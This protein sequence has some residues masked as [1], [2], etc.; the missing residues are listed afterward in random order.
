MRLDNQTPLEAMAFRQFAA[1]GSL[2]CVV[3]VRGTFLHE[4]DAPLA[5]AQEQVPF[6]FEDVYAG[7]PHTSPMLMQGDLVP[8]KPGTDVTFLGSSFAPGHDPLSHWTAEIS[9]GPLQKR[10]LISGPRT[11]VPQFTS[12]G[13]IERRQK[14]TGWLLS[15]AEPANEVSLSW[16]KAFGGAVPGNLAEGKN[17]DVHREN[18]LGPGLVDL[19]QTDPDREF[20]AHQIDDALRPVTDWRAHGES[21]HGLGPISPWWRQRQ[22]YSGTYDDRWREDRHPLLPEDFDPRFWQCAHP[23]LIAIPHLSGDERYELLNLHPD[24]AHARGRLPGATLAVYCQGGD[25]QSAGWH[26]LSLDGVHFDF[27]DGMRSVMLTWRARF[28]LNEAETAMLTL[29]RVRV[30]RRNDSQEAA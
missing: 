7:D 18:P 4:Q 6:Q 5:L 10:L 12:T 9:V 20:P 29:K 23:D 25:A 11:W 13:F 16:S 2:D 8:N 19:D 26:V 22:K 17:A 24:F 14:L 27:R 30:A 3:S 28:A 21:P 1:D 15:D